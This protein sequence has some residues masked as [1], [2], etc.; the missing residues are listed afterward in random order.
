MTRL[1]I[2]GSDSGTWGA[3]LNDFLSVEHNEDGTLKDAARLASVTGKADDA[4]VVHKTGNETLTGTKNFTGTLQKSGKAV[5]AADELAI[6]AADYGAV[7]D[8]STDNTT[9]LQNAINAASAA[10]RVL[11][12]PG[13]TFRHGSLTFPARVR[14]AG[15]ACQRTILSYTGSGTALANSTPGVRIFDVDISNLTLTTST[16]AIGI[17]LDSVSTSTFTNILVNGFSD[18]AVYLHS[19]VSGG[20][21]YNRFYNVTV[22]NAPTGFRLRGESSNANV[23]HACRANI[24]SA[25]GW[26]LRDSNDNTVEATQIEDCGT[27]VYLDGTTPGAQ[28]ASRIRDVRVEGCTVGINIASA[29]VRDTVIDGLWWDGSTPTPIADSGTTTRRTGM[30]LSARDSNSIVE[31]DSGWQFVSGDSINLGTSSSA[32]AAATDTP[33]YLR[34]NAINS[35]SAVGTWIG[36]GATLNTSGARIVGFSRDTPVTHAQPV[37]YVNQDGSYEFASGVKVMSG[38]GSPEGSVT[39]PQGSMYLRAN[40]GAGTTLYIKE[41][42]AGNAG[43]VAK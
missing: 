3:I 19:T 17:D 8:N 35:S 30:L 27:G 29:N 36:N 15:V 31:L 38:N 22:Q 12:I 4:A 33:L 10:G 20:C 37:S 16:G 7:G 21:V 6:N 32:L 11:I 24:C 41:S 1:P 40:G 18:V 39:A 34:G 43:W 2:P 26:D 42:G 5:V 25:F 9:F 13:G 28:D 14:I 23:W